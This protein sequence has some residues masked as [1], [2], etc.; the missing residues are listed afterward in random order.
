MAAMALWADKGR[1]A[2]KPYAA[3]G[4]YINKMSDYCG[5]CRYDVRKKTGEDACPFN[6]LYWHFLVRNRKLLEKN[7]RINRVYGTWDRMDADKRKDYLASAD[8]VLDN[9]V[10]AKR[11][12]A[13]D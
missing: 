8:A 6:P 9:L 2:S 5:P 3:S 4:N 7:M 12:W 1:L 10:P 13:R 11:G